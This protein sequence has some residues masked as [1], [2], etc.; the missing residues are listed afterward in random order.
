MSPGVLDSLN[1]EQ[2]EAVTHIEGPLLILAGPGSGKTRVIT[3]KIAYLLERGVPP[4]NI[5]GVTFTNKA[6]GE[7]RARVEAL[8]SAPLDGSLWL[9]T[10]HAACARILRS[11]ISRLSS[12]YNSGFTIFD[13][14]DQREAIAQAL[15]EMDVPTEEMSPALCASLINRAK[16]ELIG[17]EEFRGRY[18]GRLESYM[19]E[20]VA[21]VYGRYQVLLEGSNAV[22]FADLLRLTVKLFQSAPDVLQHYRG[23]FQYLLVD[24]YQDINHAQ[25]ALTRLW[26]EGSQNISVVG[27]EDQA[28]FSWRGSDPSYILRFQRDFPG[29]RVIELRRHYRWP[30]GDRIFKAAQRVIA[31][32]RQRVKSDGAALLQGR[33]EPIRLCLARDE[34]GEAEMVAR[35]IERL[36]RDEG[37]ELSQIAVLYRVN[38]LSRVLEEAL[39]RYGIPYEVVRGLRF[40]ERREVKDALAYLKFLANPEDEISLLR[41]LRRPKRGV[42]ETTVA[43]VQRLASQERISLWGAMRRAAER[44]EGVLKSRQAQS[45]RAFVSLMEGLLE[46]SETLPPSGLA[47]EALERSG[48]L[49]ELAQSPDREERLGN[50]RELLGLLAEY[51]RQGVRTLSG[52]LEQIALL[53]DVDR[54]AGEEGRVALMTLHASKG[55]EFDVVFIAGLEE[56]LLPHARSVAEGMLEEERRLF[57]VGMTRAR[58]RLY[59]SLANQRSLYGS[60]M[61]NGPSRFLAELPEE[62]LVLAEGELQ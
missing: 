12:I 29:A 47:A 31:H 48:Y 22:D 41:A 24:E 6:A 60:L 49:R 58:R 52:C 21:R 13:E 14:G 42:G 20:I 19:L 30:S 59:L 55:L 43:A 39:L 9:H 35:G 4:E 8:L 57:Y 44:P 46:L 25:Y 32:N 56:N 28:I 53:S 15:K 11:Q 37:V 62:D 23:R 50:L 7:M 17:P 1:P 3:H 36:R 54:Y 40:Y 18:A 61:L 16:D 45:L 27:D 26:G 33:G 10:F 38:T 34:R 5:L 2:R 51:E